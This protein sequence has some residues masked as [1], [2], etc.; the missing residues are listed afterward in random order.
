MMKT[1]IL[2]CALG[3]ARPDCS[4]DTAT[5]MIQG[6]DATGLA[7]CGFLGQAYLASTS[8]AD[9]LDDG[10]Y[11]KILCTGGDVMKAGGAA[12]PQDLAQ[13]EETAAR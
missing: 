4:A 7:S 5:S 2:I 9:Y 13:A 1:V 3:I 6:P 8:L 12:K 10:H 11:M